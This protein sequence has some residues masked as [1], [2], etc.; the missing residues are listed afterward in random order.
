M[1]AVALFSGLL[2]S[3]VFPVGIPSAVANPCAKFLSEVEMADLPP[4]FR[5]LVSSG[6][7]KSRVIEYDQDEI[8]LDFYS[9]I[10]REIESPF[11]GK[12][13]DELAK[14]IAGGR[15]SNSEFA[16]VATLM[17]EGGPS[18]KAAVE[19]EPGKKLRLRFAVGKIDANPGRE[20]LELQAIQVAL[21]Q[22]LFAKFDEKLLS[23]I[24]IEWRFANRSA[25][26]GEAVSRLVETS[27]KTYAKRCGWKKKSLWIL[28]VPASA[29]G[30]VALGGSIGFVLSDDHVDPT[31]GAYTAGALGGA[32]GASAAIWRFYVSCGKSGS[33]SEAYG[34]RF[35]RVAAH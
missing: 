20:L 1:V 28:A 21:I 34:L 14:A 8:F 15:V 19:K 32:A 16:P 10:E 2:L 7:F 24:S 23:E 18:L 25:E 12:T 4:F 17:R 27:E 9:K 3:G 6:A 33:A 29:V 35:V 30:G 31:S 11:E 26:F 22:K 13:A 5:D